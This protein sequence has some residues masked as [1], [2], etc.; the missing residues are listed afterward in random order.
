MVKY[1]WDDLILDGAAI[2]VISFFFFA[3]LGV[4]QF[5]IAWANS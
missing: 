1:R 5:L 2:A 4:V 3:G